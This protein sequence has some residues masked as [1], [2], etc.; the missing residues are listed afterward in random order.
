[1]DNHRNHL[2]EVSLQ[3]PFWADCVTHVNGVLHLT[4]L[5]FNVKSCA[6]K[7]VRPVLNIK[8]QQDKT[9]LCALTYGR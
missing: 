7:T 6:K 4:S 1:M 9:L 3:K 2:V 5:G 8:S